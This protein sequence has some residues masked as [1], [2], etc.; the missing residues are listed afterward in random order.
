MN[1]LHVSA[2]IGAAV[3]LWVLG[4]TLSVLELF[5]GIHSGPS[6]VT[7]ATGAAVLNVR[8]YF[9]QFAD[10]QQNAFDLGR[11]YE[12]GKVRPLH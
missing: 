12:S 3:L 2:T 6:G 8:A 9:C 1:D 4:G 10:R 5:T 7:I 11:D